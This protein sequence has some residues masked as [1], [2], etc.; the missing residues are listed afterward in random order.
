MSQKLGAGRNWSL[1]HS[2]LWQLILAWV[3]DLSASPYPPLH[4]VW[5]SLGFFVSWCIGLAQSK[6]SQRERARWKLFYHL[7]SSIMCT[8]L[9]LWR[10]S[11]VSTKFQGKRI[12]TPPLIGGDQRHAECGHCGH[13]EIQSSTFKQQ[14]KEESLIIMGKTGWWSNFG[15]QMTPNSTLDI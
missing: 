11:Q 8:I 6:H 15:E 5:T 3:G 14:D 10:Q 1:V 4:I 2:Q 12:Q 13:L 9:H 7:S